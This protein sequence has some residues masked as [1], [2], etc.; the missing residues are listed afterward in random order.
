MNKGEA[1]MLCAEHWRWMADTGERHTSSF[2]WRPEYTGKQLNIPCYCCE[3]TEQN[4]IGCR[5]CPLKGYAWKDHC[6]EDESVYDLWYLSKNV[7]DRKRY[8]LKMVDACIEAIKNY[9]PNE[10][11]YYELDG[12]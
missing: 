1:L 8:A 6:L 7:E 9:N 10:V 2:F 4:G 5:Q 11:P 12:N 3:Y